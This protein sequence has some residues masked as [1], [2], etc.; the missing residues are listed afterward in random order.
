MNEL[1]EIFEDKE[2]LKIGIDLGRA[3][4]LLKQ[5]NIDL[6]GIKYDISIAG[7]IQMNLFDQIENDEEKNRKEKT[8]LYSY[9]IYKIRE[10]TEQKL[11]E[12]NA[13]ELFNN[14]DMPTVQEC[15]QMKKNLK[16]L[17]KH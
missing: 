7:Y 6:Q 9:L 2:I 12:I 17:V 8:C 3:Y 11:E 13:L 15:M 5:E 16:N 1:K 10:I 4:I 14:I